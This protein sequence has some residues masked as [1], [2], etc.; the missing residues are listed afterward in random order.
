MADNYIHDNWGPGGWADTDNANTTYNG[1]A[2]IRN[3]GPAIFE[4]ISY[5]F[6]IR[7]NYMADNG[8]IDGLSNPGFPTPAIYI[9]ESGSDRVFGG[10]PACPEASCSGRGSYTRRSLISGNVLVD[11]G[12]SIF[13]WQSSNRF[14]SDGADGICTLVDGGRRGRFT[15]SGCRSHLTSAS[16]SMSTYAGRATGS[17]PRDWWDGCLWRTENVSITHNVIDFSPA[18][19]TDC[20]QADWPACGAGG[21]F[22]EYGSVCAV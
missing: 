12:G 8:W 5:N 6:S 4:E 13:L 9:S 22:S 18:R 10:V 2:I 15:I 11:N 7:N 14:C 21:M 3:E 19:I 16:I 17:P 1:N 20:N